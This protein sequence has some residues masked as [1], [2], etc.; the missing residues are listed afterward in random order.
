MLNY[1]ILPAHLAHIDIEDDGKQ[2]NFRLIRYWSVI[3]TV[4]QKGLHWFIHYVYFPAV[5][6]AIKQRYAVFIAFI[7]VVVL[8]LGL[9][10]QGKVKTV[11][12][13][14]FP[15]QLMSVEMEIDSRAPYNLTVSN[16]NKIEAIGDQLNK[17]Y[18]AQGL[19]P[20]L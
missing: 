14:E 11:F 9:I 4:A 5:E 2:S 13:P 15:G 6:W 3:Q 1:F 16:I 7:A 10:A 17:D 18:L 20:C 8:G 19:V 12:F